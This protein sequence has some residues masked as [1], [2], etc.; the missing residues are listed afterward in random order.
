M[1][2]ADLKK[3][4]IETN[5][6][7]L[8]VVEAGKADGPLLI[9]LHGFPEFWYA[10]RYQIDYFA[11]AGYRVVVPDQRG[12]N[13]SDKPRKIAEYNLDE[14]TKD[15]IGLIDYYQRERAVLIAHDWG[16]AVAWWAAMTCPN[17]IEKLIVMNVPHPTVMRRHLKN[18][19]EQRR[20][21]RYIFFFQFPFLPEW[22]MQKNQWDYAIRALTKTSRPGTFSSEDIALYQ[23][24]WSQP[25][26]LTSM[27]HWYRASLR[28]RPKRK[29]PAQ[30]I[31]PTLLIWGEKDRFLGG[32]MA[33]ESIALCEQGQL[34]ML[35]SA[36]HWVQ[37]EEP[38]RV[39][40][41]IAD[42]LKQ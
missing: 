27:I 6:I 12:Y 17:R 42:F 37:H 41:L 13:L 1:I 14:L 34:E 28:H 33:G 30:V 26:A 29:L 7:R 24:A 22:R 2:K 15:A 32:E 38:D 40:A 20:R 25:G 36:T 5:S 3:H 21:S 19:P 4:F 35:E 11:Q 18:N 39:N 10:W 8:H 16:G 9:F 31:V 23:E